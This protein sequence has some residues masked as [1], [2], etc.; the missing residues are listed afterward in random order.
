MYAGSVRHTG[1]FTSVPCVL[2]QTGEL[3]YLASWAA[4]LAGIGLRLP[5]QQLEALCSYVGDNREE[6][7]PIDRK[8]LLRAFQAWGYQPGLALLS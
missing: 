6:L 1:G 5:A 3:P 2:S 7:Q 4:C 8:N